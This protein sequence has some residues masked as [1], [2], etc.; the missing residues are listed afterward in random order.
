MQCKLI[1]KLAYNPLVQWISV[2]VPLNFYFLSII[3]ANKAAKM[4]DRIDA[5]SK[6]NP[7]APTLILSICPK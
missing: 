7:I 2:P 1:L 4:E 6:T 5:N 3:F